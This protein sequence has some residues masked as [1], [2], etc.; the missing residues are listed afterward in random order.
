MR[1]KLPDSSPTVAK[2]VLVAVTLRS[3]DPTLIGDVGLKT[4]SML[5]KRSG[6]PRSRMRST[7]LTPKAASAINQDRRAREWFRA[8][9]ATKARVVEAPPSPPVKKY[10]G[11]SGFQT[12]GLS[13][14]RP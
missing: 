2:P 4:R 13:T 14:G 1:G 12:G 5:R 9:P 6:R 3:H 8:S 7:G 11:T 10:Q